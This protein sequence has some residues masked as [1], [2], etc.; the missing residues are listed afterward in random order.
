MVGRP[1]D[2]AG[3]Y[4]L[5]SHSGITLAPAL[6]LFSSQELLG[7]VRDPLLA[8]YHPDRLLRFNA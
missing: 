4:L 7:G 3:L 2:T 5:L 6:G 1:K 8:N